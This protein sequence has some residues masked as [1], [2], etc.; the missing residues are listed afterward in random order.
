MSDPRTHIGTVHH[1][2]L[3]VDDLDKSLEFYM[4][5]LGCKRLPRP[6][7]IP[8]PPGAWMQA[9]DTQVHITARPVD[10]IVGSPPTGIEPTASHIA[11]HTDDLDAAEASLRERGFVYERGNAVE[12]IFIQDPSG[13]II[14]LTPY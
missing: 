9:G 12:Q 4:G 1:V 10:A 8:G 11:F 6:G 2:S 13:N 14:E 7:N 5:V 3:R